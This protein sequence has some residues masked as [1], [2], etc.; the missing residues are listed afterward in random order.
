MKKVLAVVLCVCIALTLSVAVMA[1]SSP[2]TKVIVRKGNA[3]KQDNAT[4]PEDTAVEIGE[5]DTV[6]V[7]ANEKTYGKFNNWTIYVINEDGEYEE[8]VQGVDYEIVSGSLND[9]TLVIKPINKITIAG[10]YNGTITDPAKASTVPGK[11]PSSSKTGD[12]EVMYIAL[13]LLAA[14]AVALGAKKQ[15]AK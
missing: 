10:N 12:I 9:G 4:I 8:A 1:E 3:Y 11:K 13:A 7:K 6:K 2:Q 14:G 5:D 15:F